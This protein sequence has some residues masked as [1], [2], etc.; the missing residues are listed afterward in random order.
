MLNKKDIS[1]MPTKQD[2]PNEDP[3]TGEDLTEGRKKKSYGKF[4]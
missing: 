2:I 4:N 3:E 1:I